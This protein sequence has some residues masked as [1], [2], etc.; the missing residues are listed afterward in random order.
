MFRYS[1]YGSA[2]FS[3]RQ[4]KVS[5]SVCQNTKRVWISKKKKKKT[6]SISEKIWG[7]DENNRATHLGTHAGLPLVV[8]LVGH[9]LVQL[10]PQSFGLPVGDPLLQAAVEGAA[11]GRVQV[12]LCAED[13]EGLEGFLAGRGLD[14]VLKEFPHIVSL[15]LNLSHLLL[16]R[17]QA[18]GTHWDSRSLSDVARPWA[19][20]AT[21]CPVWVGRV[22][23]GRE[24][25]RGGRKSDVIS[26]LE[27]CIFHILNGLVTLSQIITRFA[28]AFPNLIWLNVCLERQVVPP[29]MTSFFSQG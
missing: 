2:F 18:V 26:Q 25:G 15:L 3:T 19:Q 8:L 10:T 24:E 20:S 21:P 14:E 23:W 5:Q 4:D 1:I 17:R 11:V 7:N 22:C 12:Q 9:P 13:V 28:A 6:D 16:L 29:T 27:D